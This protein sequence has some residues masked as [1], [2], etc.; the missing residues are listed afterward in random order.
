MAYLEDVT[1]GYGHV[2]VSRERSVR[3]LAELGCVYESE[4]YPHGEVWLAA[5]AQPFFLPDPVEEDGA[6]WF[7][8]E[9]R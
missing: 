9:T 3:V 7:T 8:A 5:G 4:R 6:L 2:G 1:G